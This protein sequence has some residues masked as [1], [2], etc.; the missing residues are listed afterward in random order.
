[1]LELR[2]G[3]LC[4]DGTYFTGT[5]KELC[6]IIYR[7]TQDFSDESITEAKEFAAAMQDE[8][9]VKILTWILESRHESAAG[10]LDLGQIKIDM[11][12]NTV[13]EDPVILELS[14]CNIW[15]E[16]DKVLI[17]MYWQEDGRFASAASA[18]D[19]DE[20]LSLEEG[21]LESILGQIRAYNT[22]YED[23]ENV[24]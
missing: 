4:T 8:K 16:N 18:Y 11:Y 2:K 17:A 9:S 19:L 10:K 14:E 7:Y 6:D 3:I 5:S 21:S 24:G 22:I 1:M 13:T 20:F 12:N 15:R 23:E